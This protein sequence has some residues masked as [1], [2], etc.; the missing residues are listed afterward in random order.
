MKPTD[1]EIAV[2]PDTD[3][4][5]ETETDVQEVADKLPAYQEFVREQRLN[6]V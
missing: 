3:T 5:V 4:L 1:E 6:E 2:E